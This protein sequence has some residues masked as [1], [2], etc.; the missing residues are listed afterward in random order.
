MM[1]TYIPAILLALGACSEP[2]STQMLSSRISAELS[3]TQPCERPANVEFFRE[4]ARVRFPETFLFLSGRTDL[5]PCGK[6]ALTSVI[7]AM[8]VPSI[9]QVVIEPQS[10]AGASP[11]EF[12]LRRAE[13]VQRALSNVGFSQT[14][15]Q[16]SVL[17]QPASTPSPGALGIV[18]LITKPA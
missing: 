15:V 12:A 17:V 13:T 3:Q 6:Y 8:L 14:Q 9:M 1:R 11:S 10:N 18:L 7:Q 5:S 16:P 2:S 4:G